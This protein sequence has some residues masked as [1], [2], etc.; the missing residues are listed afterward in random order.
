VTAHDPV[1]PCRLN[2]QVPRDLDTICLKCLQKDPHNRYPSA[3]ELADDLQ[4]YLEGKPIKARPIR[5]WR[6]PGSGP[7]AG[8]Q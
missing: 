2:A 7:G 4:R 5:P 3:G 6:G 1:P 8:Q